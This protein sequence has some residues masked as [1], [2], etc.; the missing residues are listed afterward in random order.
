M[1]TITTTDY[2]SITGPDNV[3]YPLNTLAYNI[4]SWGGDRTAPPTPRGDN[5]LV[6]FSVGQRY[7]QKMP[8]QRTITLGMWVQ[9]SSDT[10]TYTSAHK[11]K[12]RDNYALLKFILW[13]RLDQF[14]ITKR[15]TDTAGVLQTA[16]ALAEFAGGLDLAPDSQDHG[17]FT[18]DL[19]LADPFF[20]GPVQNITFDSTS[21]TTFHYTGTILGDY[22]CRRCSFSAT[23]KPTVNI[24]SP[25]I[26]V[27]TTDIP[28]FWSFPGTILASTALVGD[29]GAQSFAI[30]STN[31]SYGILHGGYPDWLLLNPGTINLVFS[32]LTSGWSGT[33]SYY[34]TYW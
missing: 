32:A 10:G 15:W 19:K 7:V 33:F 8:D 18:V 28:N 1:A 17:K 29:M 22:Y 26:D 34:P 2:W 31:F 27:T 4:S 24:V 13:N 21:G 25:R 14:I 3:D 30:N 9:G 12:F 6:P 23:A 20:Y 16:T 5:I 11:Q